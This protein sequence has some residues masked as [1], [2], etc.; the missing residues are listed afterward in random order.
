MAEGVEPAPREEGRR[1]QVERRA[2]VLAVGALLAAACCSTVALWVREEHGL[3]R[4]AALEM[5]AAAAQ[6]RQLAAADAEIR[7]YASELGTGRAPAPAPREA[8]GRKTQ[9]WNAAANDEVHVDRHGRLT[10]SGRAR[11]ASAR[12]PAGRASNAR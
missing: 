6:S 11:A 7:G 3:A 2:R 1:L 9:L 5:R 8:A 4:P 10:V 12:A